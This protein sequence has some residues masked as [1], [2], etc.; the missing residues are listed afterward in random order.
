MAVE[1]VLP[2]KK[3]RGKV[4][5]IEEVKNVKRWKRKWYSRRK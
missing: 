4:D 1:E 2:N 3:K 5:K